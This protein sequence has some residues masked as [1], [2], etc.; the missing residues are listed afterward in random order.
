MSERVGLRVPS[1]IDTAGNVAAQYIN[2]QNLGSQKW[3]AH[4]GGLN[5]AA[6]DAVVHY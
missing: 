4:K 2:P 6:F 3:S 1:A 5:A